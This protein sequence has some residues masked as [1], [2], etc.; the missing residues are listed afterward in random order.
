MLRCEI[1]EFTMNEIEYYIQNYKPFDKAGSYGFRNGWEWLKSK[2][3]MEA[4]I[5][6]WDFLLIWFTKF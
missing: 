5:P 6:L 4:F 1:D 2:D 3:D